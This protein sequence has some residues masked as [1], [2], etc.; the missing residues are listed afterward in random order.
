MIRFLSSL[1]GLIRWFLGQHLAGRTT[2]LRASRIW[3]LG[4]FL[5]GLRPLPCKQPDQGTERSSLKD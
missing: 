2:N 1:Y 3:R 5:E 4:P